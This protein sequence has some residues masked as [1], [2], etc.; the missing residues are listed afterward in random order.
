MLILTVL[1]RG[2]YHWCHSFD[3]QKK[4]EIGCIM[5]YGSRFVQTLDQLIARLTANARR[6][7]QGTDFR[8]VVTLR[9]GAVRTK[10]NLST[11]HEFVVC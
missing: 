6:G 9:N 3:K 5:I 7:S 10:Q 1:T 4:S 11:A 2:A 8:R